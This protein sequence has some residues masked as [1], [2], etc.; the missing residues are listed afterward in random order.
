MSLHL[1]L[2]HPERSTSHEI[3]LDL[4]ELGMVVHQLQNR[5][6]LS[7]LLAM[8]GEIF[9]Y[10]V[11]VPGA[12]GEYDTP[13][14]TLQ[15]LY[16]RTIPVQTLAVSGWRDTISFAQQQQITRYAR[17]FPDPPQ[18]TYLRD[19]PTQAP[20]LDRTYFEDLLRRQRP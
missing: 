8:Q 7:R 12:E 10:V 14:K 17:S 16:H 5:D 13:L 3:A 2:I 1:A 19:D 18:V 15:F 6:A 20:L 9:H 11:S 4:Q